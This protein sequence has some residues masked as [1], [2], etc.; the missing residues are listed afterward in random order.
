MNLFE[1]GLNRYFDDE[2]IKKLQTAKIG[3]AGAGGL[4]SNCASNLVRCGI[5]NLKIADFDNVDSSNLNRQ[6]FFIHQIGMKKTDALRLN[7]M[8]INPDL[9]I[10]TL[11]TKITHNNVLEIFKECDIIVEAF[12]EAGSKIM[13]AEEFGSSG[14]L[15]ITV[16]GIGGYGRSDEIRIKKIKPNFFIVG[17]FTTEVSKKNPPLSPRINIAAAKQ[18]D[19]VIEYILNTDKEYE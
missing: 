14:K 8:K 6:F 7:L 9:N 13:L 3:I 4:G 19:I 12:D 5:R 10:E 1:E 2:S 11:Y 15:L 18:A 16:S 17:D